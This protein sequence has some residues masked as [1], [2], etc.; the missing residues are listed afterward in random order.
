[1]FVAD[2]VHGLG[3]MVNSAHDVQI[4]GYRLAECFRKGGCTEYARGMT[5]F[6]LDG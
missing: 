2:D 4:P 5:G 6:G 3:S 1:M